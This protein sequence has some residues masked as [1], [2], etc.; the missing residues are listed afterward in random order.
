MKTKKGILLAGT[1]GNGK[2]SS[3]DKFQD[4]IEEMAAQIRQEEENPKFNHFVET[5]EVLPKK[6]DSDSKRYIEAIGQITSLIRPG[7]LTALI[8]DLIPPKKP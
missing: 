7:P 2:S 4:I 3:A 8:Q 5:G 6:T 1:P